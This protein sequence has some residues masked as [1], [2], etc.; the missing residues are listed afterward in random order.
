MPPSLAVEP[1]I[2]INALLMRISFTQHLRAH[3]HTHTPLPHTPLSL[4]TFTTHIF[5]SHRKPI[6][7]VARFSDTLPL[8]GITAVASVPSPAL[9]TLYS[10]GVAIVAH[11]CSTNISEWHRGAA[12]ERGCRAD[13]ATRISIGLNRARTQVARLHF[14]FWRERERERSRTIN[15]SV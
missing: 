5:K 4:A 11:V 12:R 8:E 9:S 15:Q 14:T 10:S 6:S 7:Q 2:P 13:R 1:L 3:T